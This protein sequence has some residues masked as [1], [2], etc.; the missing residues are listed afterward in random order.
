LLGLLRLAPVG[1]RGA[2]RLARASHRSGQG[3]GARP[4]LI[5]RIAAA[6]IGLGLACAG[7]AT[8]AVTPPLPD[9]LVATG[10]DL[11]VQTCAACLQ[12]QKKVDLV[13]LSPGVTD[14]RSM[15]NKLIKF[16]PRPVITMARGAALSTPEIQP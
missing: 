2:R 8:A 1:H 3:P 14:S 16:S 15:L 9:P 12:L 7:C 4:A 11:A 13:L 5:V 6:L 10:H